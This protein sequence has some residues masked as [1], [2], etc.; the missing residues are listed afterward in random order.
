MLKRTICLTLIL[1]LGFPAGALAYKRDV[2]RKA[3][4]A[5][6][7]APEAPAPE[8]SV[9]VPPPKPPAP[10]EGKGHEDPAQMEKG[11]QPV[12]V[13]R[14]MTEEEYD[15]AIRSAHTIA[16]TG[17]VLSIAGGLAAI[18][19]SAYAIARKD[20]KTVGAIIGASGLALGLTGGLLQVWAANK[21]QEA[22][23]GWSYGVAPAFD[24]SRR[25]AGLSLSASF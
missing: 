18:G 23:Q 9:S 22:E 5:G 11:R 10:G 1:T 24:P 4:S 17:F 21:R 25:F 6:A 8:P 14:Q 3:P 7:P 2:P 15:K 16:I 12:R 13:P 20:D 19:G